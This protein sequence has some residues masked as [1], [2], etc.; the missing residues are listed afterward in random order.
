MWKADLLSEPTLE[1]LLDK[2]INSHSSLAVPPSKTAKCQDLL[3]CSASNP[4]TESSIY[5]MMSLVDVKRYLKIF[6]DKT[7][8]TKINSS[9]LFANWRDEKVKLR[10]CNIEQYQAEFIAI[11][12]EWNK[13]NSSTLLKGFC[14]SL[15]SPCANIL[16]WAEHG[17]LNKFLL[18]EKVSIKFL[19]KSAITLTRAVEYLVSKFSSFEIV[20]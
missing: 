17:K 9:I 18:K 11:S 16:E 7:K 15:E 8:A 20:D 13:L 3:I 1:K 10:V 4:Q 5:G 19:L 14:M 12:T 2:L 6:I